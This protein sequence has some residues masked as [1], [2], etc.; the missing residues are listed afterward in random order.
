MPSAMYAE[1]HKLA[2]YADSCCPWSRYANI[3]GFYTLINITF[4]LY[5]KC[6]VDQSI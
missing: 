6:Q 3:V 5:V 4:G 1:C 2:L